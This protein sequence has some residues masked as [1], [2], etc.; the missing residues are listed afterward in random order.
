MVL[1]SGT[2]VKYYTNGALVDTIAG[3]SIGSATGD[4]LT[5][6]SSWT[7]NKFNGLIDD[8]RVYNRALTAAEIKALAA[9]PQ[10]WSIP[11]TSA[12]WGGR[13]SSTSTDIDSKWGTDDSSDKWLAVG[14]GDYTVVSRSGRTAVAGSTETIQFR[15][16]VGTDK[17]QAPGTYQGAVTVT[18]TAL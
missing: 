5:I 13:L 6:G 12:Y 9:I 16:E 18:V 3:A 15:M 8:V 4:P 14:N 1:T 11:T 17:V 2:N 10:T 7:D